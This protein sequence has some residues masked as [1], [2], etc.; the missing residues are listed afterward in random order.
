MGKKPKVTRTNH[1]VH[2]DCYEE[3]A[4]KT[5]EKEI[6]KVLNNRVLQMMIMRKIR[7]R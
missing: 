6:S 4:A 5:C 3:K 1:V 2:I 7:S